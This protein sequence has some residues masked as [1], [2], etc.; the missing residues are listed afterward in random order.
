MVSLVVIMTSEE[1]GEH[2]TKLG[3]MSSLG[4]IGPPGVSIVRGKLDAV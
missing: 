4:Q 1:N 2:L 3:L